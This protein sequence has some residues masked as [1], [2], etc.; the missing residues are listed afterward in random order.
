MASFPCPCGKGVRDRHLSLPP[1]RPRLLPQ[2]TALRTRIPS[3]GSA[4]P[5]PRA[6]PSTPDRRS[7]LSPWGRGPGVSRAARAARP[8]LR[9]GGG[10]PSSRPRDT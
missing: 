7:L 6:R 2:G 1:P 8:L 10:A 5:V 9:R 3:E 4:V